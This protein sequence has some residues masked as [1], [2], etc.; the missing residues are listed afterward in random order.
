MADCIVAFMIFNSTK[1]NAMGKKLNIFF[2]NSISSHKW[3]GGE[4]WMVTAAKGLSER[5]HRVMVSGKSNSIFLSNARNYGLEIIPLNFLEDYNPFKIW[6]TK[7][8]LEREKVDVIVLNLKKD[9]RVAGIAARKAKVPV[10]IA[11]NGIQLFRD[12]WKH[13][14]TAGLVD[15]I[16]TNTNSIRDVYNQFSW[17][18]GNKTKVIYNGLKM[19]GAIEPQNIHDIWNIP[20]NHVVFVAAGRLTIQKGFDLLIN[21]ISDVKDSLKPFSVLIAGTGKERKTLENLITKKGLVGTVKLIGFQHE[22]SRVIQAADFVIMPSRHEGMPNV[23]MESMAL[24]KPVFASNVNGV[25]ELINHRKTGY[26]MDELTVDEISKAIRFGMDNHGSEEIKNWGI[27]AK[28]QISNQFTFEGM[29]DQLESYFYTHM[30]I[31]H[32]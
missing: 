12:I 23:A 7:R 11:R 2:S 31:S 18:D 28:Q 14:K 25:P 20:K 13:K 29:L 30:N 6:Y 16:I 9:I 21:A 1:A 26:I 32:R 10:I 15:G 27:E 17:M 8:I 4:K 22:L 19:N 3:G 24:G 5:G